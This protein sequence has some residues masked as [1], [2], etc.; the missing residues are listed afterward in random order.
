MGVTRE[1]NSQ[2]TLLFYPGGPEKLRPSAL[3]ASTFILQAI[4]LAALLCILI[5]SL[6]PSSLTYLL[7][8]CV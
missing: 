6:Y 2:E 3:R 4:L 7:A 1:D 5:S 8:V